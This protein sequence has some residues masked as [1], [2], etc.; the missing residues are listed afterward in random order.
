M[1]LLSENVGDP[2]DNDIAKGIRL[3]GGEVTLDGITLKEEKA[4]TCILTVRNLFTP[5]ECSRVISYFKNHPE[6]TQPGKTMGGVRRIKNCTDLEMKKVDVESTELDTMVAERFQV[7]IGAVSK[8]IPLF[9]IDPIRDTGY[10]IQHYVPGGFYHWH[11]DWRPG[12]KM[13]IILYLNEVESDGETEFWYQ[14]IKIKPEVGKVLIFPT[15]GAY[16]H[17]GITP[18]SG[19]KFIITTFLTTEL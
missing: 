8:I 4:G 9:F 5:D 7:L 19:D 15:E 1:D 18:T 14:N 3:C 16:T 6:R 17:R 10:Q 12:R 2:Y 11:V 13:A